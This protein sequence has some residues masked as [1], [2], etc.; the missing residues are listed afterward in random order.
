[1]VTVQNIVVKATPSG[2]SDTTEGL[3]QVDEQFDETTESFED[4]TGQF[5][6]AESRWK[7]ALGSIVS[8]LAV[9]VAGLFNLIPSLG[10]AMDGL[11]AIASAVG[12]QM[13]Q[14]LRPALIPLSDLFYSIA[15]AIFELN[16]ALGYLVGLLGTIGALVGGVVASYLA[17]IGAT[18]GLVGVLST[19]S[20]WVGS[21]AGSIKGLLTGLAGI[22]SSSLAAAAALGVLI[23]T[24][25]VFAL[26]MT[27]A[28][29]AVKNFG[30]WVRDKMPP[31]VKDGFVSLIA[32]A[33]GPLAVIGGAIRGF[34]Q[35]TLKGGLV[36]G[37][38]E[39]A[40]QSIQIFNIF[41]DAINNTLGRLKA[42]FAGVG[43]EIVSTITD[44]ADT[45]VS[46]LR[47]LV[48]RAVSFGRQIVESIIEGIRQKSSELADAVE[49]H[50]AGVIDDRLPSSSAEEGPLSTLNQSGRALVDTFAGG[51]SANVGTVESAANDMAGAANQTPVV[52]SRESRP[53]LQMDGKNVT[54]QT[55]R[56]R[57]AE[58][59]RRGRDG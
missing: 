10:A 42:F 55:G 23:G 21:V 58:T 13:D 39:A 17:W 59:N 12:W 15:N 2:I 51:I 36:N 28:L 35:G 4:A 29:D 37:F 41:A 5:E 43:R 52:A 44:L 30:T 48:D 38:Q 34:V 8:G 1:M 18:E 19:L 22:V 49:Q 26:E 47:E 45:V 20:G 27:G 6:E 50:I 3:E 54:K 16:G 14:V 11:A 32:I 9:S 40:N 46:K 24:L 56:Y 7:A 57:A 31:A 25:G 33:V 53:I